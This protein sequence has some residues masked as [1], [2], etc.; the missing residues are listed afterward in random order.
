MNALQNNFNLIWQDIANLVPRLVA[1][2]IVL[3]ACIWVGRFLGR[4]TVRLLS[5]KSEAKVYVRF[6]QQLATWFLGLLGLIL[7]LNILG[8]GNIAMSL[9]AG[10]GMAAVVF[11]F[12]FREIGENFIA[13]FFLTF[14]RAF[15]VGDIIESESL[16]GEVKTLS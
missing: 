3:F 15:E 6:L 9:L 14:S 4:V 10:G 13:G 5:E 1:A 7:A 8:L 2:L 16:V 11:G 12:A